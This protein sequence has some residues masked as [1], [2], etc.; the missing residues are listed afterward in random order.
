MADALNQLMEQGYTAFINR[1]A[2]GRKLPAE[3]VKKIAEGRVW[4]G[5]HAVQNGLIDKL[6]GLEAAI[7]SAAQKA[8]LETYAVDYLQ[9]P[10]TRREQLLKQARE[11]FTMMIPNEL[12][13]PFSEKTPVIKALADS[14]VSELLTLNDPLGLYAYCITCGYN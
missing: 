1:V 14:G 10:L 5:Q 12:K 7:A 11:F 6:G 4:A 9:Q 3:A 8:G 2:E 13:A